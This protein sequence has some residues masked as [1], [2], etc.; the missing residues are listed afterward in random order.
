MIMKKNNFSSFCFFFC[1]F[2][3]CVTYCGCQKHCDVN[4]EGCF[5]FLE[6]PITVQDEVT[7]NMVEIKA[8][9]FSGDY[10]ENHIVEINESIH[11]GPVPLGC[12]QIT[13]AIPVVF[14]N[15]IPVRVVISFK[16]WYQVAFGSNYYIIKCIEKI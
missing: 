8:L 11:E 16:N 14:R 13:G 6:K 15:P 1:W 5:L 3:L 2:A 10:Y 4:Q 12:M 7:H 9:F